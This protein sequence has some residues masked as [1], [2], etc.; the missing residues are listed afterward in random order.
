MLCKDRSWVAGS[1]DD[2][3]TKYLQ[4][5]RLATSDMQV[6]SATN[7]LDRTVQTAKLWL[8]RRCLLCCEAVWWCGSVPAFQWST[9]PWRWRH[10]G[11]L[12]RWYPTCTP[13]SVTTP[14]TPTWNLAAVKASKL[15]RGYEIWRD[16]GLG[17]IRGEQKKGSVRSRENADDHKAIFILYSKKFCATLWKSCALHI[18]HL[19]NKVSSE[20]YCGPLVVQMMYMTI[21]MQLHFIQVLWMWERTATSYS[22]VCLVSVLDQWMRPKRKMGTGEANRTPW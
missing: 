10:H 20:T 2:I 16:F 11:P 4:N 19:V 13:R 1:Q 3:R 9:S 12:K 21:N 14:K 22:N 5:A 8:S 6:N 15:A 7:G 18:G 17:L